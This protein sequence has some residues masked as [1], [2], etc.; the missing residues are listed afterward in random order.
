MDEVVTGRA[1]GGPFAIFG[2]TEVAEK[3]RW[4]LNR[5]FLQPFSYVRLD[6]H[7]RSLET[8]PSNRNR[9]RQNRVAAAIGSRVQ[10]A[11]VANS[12][13]FLTTAGCRLLFTSLLQNVKGF[14]VYVT[15]GITE[16]LRGGQSIKLAYL[17]SY[18]MS[19]LNAN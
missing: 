5:V 6:V 19:A 2:H 12:F 18:I 16:R 4:L 13:V 15:V 17:L 14:F 7:H 8:P 1:E 9:Q 11:S 10:V 3:T